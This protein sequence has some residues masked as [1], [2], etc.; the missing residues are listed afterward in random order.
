MTD[1]D[2]RLRTKV[3][4]AKVTPEELEALDALVDTMGFRS[5]S[6]LLRALALG[7]L[8]VDSARKEAA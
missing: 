1:K 6:E 2:K 5:R 8:A 3:A 4:G 7:A